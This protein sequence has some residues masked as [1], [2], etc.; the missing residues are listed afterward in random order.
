[1]TAALAILSRLILQEHLPPS[2]NHRPRRLPVSFQILNHIGV[3]RFE[4]VGRS[5]AS[6]YLFWVHKA[7]I[8]VTAM[9]KEMSLMQS[10]PRWTILLPIHDKVQF[11][12]ECCASQF[13]F[14]IAH[15]KLW[16]PTGQFLLSYLLF[17]VPQVF[18]DIGL[19]S[20]P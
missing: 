19:R 16:S 7:S 18:L 20:T 5:Q 4:Q 12:N 13:S 9:R 10:A 2:A 1:M 8:D 3:Q 17:N 15:G 6:M 14:P 11:F